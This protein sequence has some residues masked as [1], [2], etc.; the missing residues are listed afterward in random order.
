MP[1]HPLCSQLGVLGAPLE[2]WHVHYV[3]ISSFGPNRN[4]LI[5]STLTLFSLGYFLVLGPRKKSPNCKMENEREF[6]V[7]SFKVHFDSTPGRQKSLS[8]LIVRNRVCYRYFFVYLFFSIQPESM[9]VD[10]KSKTYILKTLSVQIN[11]F[12]S[13]D[14][15]FVWR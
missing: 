10:T 5:K 9:V 4:C 1:G 12:S 8:H 13:A 6:L 2:R 7:T 3:P 11:I 14:S 15:N